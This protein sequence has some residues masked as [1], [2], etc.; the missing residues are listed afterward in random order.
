MI[1]S[2]WNP[3]ASWERDDMLRVVATMG[4]PTRV[5]TRAVCRAVLGQPVGRLFWERADMLRVV[6]AVGV[7]TRVCTG[8]GSLKAR[9]GA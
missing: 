6:A 4:V 9:W 1:L 8:L 7:P 2:V 5:R 3:D